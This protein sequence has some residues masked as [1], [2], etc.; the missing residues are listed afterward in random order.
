MNLKKMVVVQRI[1]RCQPKQLVY[2]QP[3]TPVPHYD[4]WRM[5]MDS[6]HHGAINAIL[7]L[8][9]RTLTIRAFI[10]KLVPREGLEPSTFS[11]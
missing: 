8:A 3:G 4:H 1:E 7:A 9:K 10:L 5:K 11:S 2:S 6:N